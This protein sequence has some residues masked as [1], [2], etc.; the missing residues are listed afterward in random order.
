MRTCFVSIPFGVKS[1]AD[2]RLLDFDFL[3]TEVIR[4]AVEAVGMECRRLDEYSPGAIWH[5]TLFSAIISS[6]LVIADITTDN[7]NVFYEIGIRHA[8]TR[9]RGQVWG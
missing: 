6:D 4:P 5:K 1:H 7:A 3:Y 9:G 8:L 2:G